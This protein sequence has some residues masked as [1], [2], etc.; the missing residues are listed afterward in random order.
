ML[1]HTFSSELVRYVGMLAQ[2]CTE[3]V[4][5]TTGKTHIAALVFVGDLT[6]CL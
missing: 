1:Q 2:L 4:A 6:A 5:D 3:A